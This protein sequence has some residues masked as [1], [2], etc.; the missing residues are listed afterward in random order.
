[1]SG[2]QFCGGEARVHDGFFSQLQLELYDLATDPTEKTNLA[3]EQEV[4]SLLR[5]FLD[6]YDWWIDG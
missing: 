6:E 5:M 3:E 4:N 1:M 2:P